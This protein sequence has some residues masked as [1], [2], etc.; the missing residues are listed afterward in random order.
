MKYGSRA[1]LQRWAGE[2]AERRGREWHRRRDWPPKTTASVD[3]RCA[4]GS[5]RSS[6]AAGRTTTTNTGWSKKTNTLPH[7]WSYFRLDLQLAVVVS[8]C[9]NSFDFLPVSHQIDIRT[10]KFLENF[11]CSENYI[12]T[13]LENKAG[14]YLKKISV[15]CNTMSLQF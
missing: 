11:M 1:D 12:C 4:L 8:D 10:A 5:N 6:H 15:R 9:M 7:L 3:S 14:S 2:E 13:L